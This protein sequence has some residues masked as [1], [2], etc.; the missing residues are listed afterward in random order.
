MEI[1]ED[2]TVELFTKGPCTWKCGDVVSIAVAPFSLETSIPVIVSSKDVIS[3]GSYIGKDV[4]NPI[5]QITEIKWDKLGNN[6]QRICH[7]NVTRDITISSR[8]KF[9]MWKKGI[10]L[11]V[12]T[13]SDRGFFGERED[14]SGP[15]I[16]E[17]IRSNLDVSLVLRSKI[18]DEF[19]TIMGLISHMAL[20]QKIDLIITTGGTGVTPRDITPDATQRLIEKR[21]WGFEHA[22]YMEGLKK[23]KNAIISRAVCGILSS[24]III[25]LPGSKKAVEENISAILPVL[26]HTLNKIKNDPSDCGQLS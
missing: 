24:S 14:R 8:N 1:I 6:T 21:L 12:I 15:L 9:H 10:S 23:T 11:C 7:L 25:N 18:P 13:I 5:F 20:D 2:Y 26:E 19:Y 16:E 22:I 17:I 4:G 3:S